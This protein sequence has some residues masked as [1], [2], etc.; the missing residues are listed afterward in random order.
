VTG[1]TGGGVTGGTGGGVTGGTGGGVTGGTGGGA[2]GG[3]GG[4]VTGGTGGT[5]GVAEAAAAAFD[6]A[7][8]KAYCDGTTAK[9]SV[10]GGN[11]IA[12]ADSYKG[13]S[14][15]TSPCSGGAGTQCPKAGAIT[16]STGGYNGGNSI[17]LTGTKAAGSIYVGFNFGAAPG[18]PN[19]ST[20]IKFRYKTAGS[21]AAAGK[22]WLD[23]GLI[24]AILVSDW[25]APNL[26]TCLAPN[27]NYD[28]NQCWNNPVYTIPAAT[29]WTEVTVKWSDFIMKGYSTA[30][31]AWWPGA[32]A[33]LDQNVIFVRIGVLPDTDRWGDGSAVAPGAVDIWID[34]VTLVK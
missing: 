19:G 20:G 2:T 9:I 15:I 22:V 3:T 31:P 10:G 29:D 33:A 30:D 6:L 12:G 14:T 27:Y 13:A 17:H 28:T 32:Q 21:V 24:P 34:T 16:C 25:A 4:D 11:W 1:G 7:A 5:G 18:T 23:L 8:W 26:G